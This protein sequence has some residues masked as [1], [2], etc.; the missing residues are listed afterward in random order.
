M[1]KP[2]PPGIKS[3]LLKTIRPTQVD[4]PQ[5]SF[6]EF[7]N[8]FMR[9]FVRGCQKGDGNGALLEFIKIQRLNF[10]VTKAIELRQR[11]TIFLRFTLSALLIGSHQGCEL[12]CRMA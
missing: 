8:K 3:A 10:H 4:Y 7:R 5:S 2:I 6:Q 11:I 9:Y 1:L 12:R